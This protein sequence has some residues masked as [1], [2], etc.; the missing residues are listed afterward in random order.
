M[1]VPIRKG[2]LSAVVTTAA[3]ALFTRGDVFA[4]DKKPEIPVGNNNPVVTAQDVKQVSDEESGNYK[5]ELPALSR[6]DAG[7]KSDGM[8]VILHYG[9]GGDLEA[10]AAADNLV[11]SDG[12]DATAYPGGKD[13]YVEYFINKER[14]GKFTVEQ[15]STGV[16]NDIAAERYAEIAAEEAKKQNLTNTAENN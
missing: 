1:N 9:K 7:L 2:F 4:E 15:V 14:A 5:H 11:N 16:A 13:G 10:M 6:R 3:L 8:K 12:L